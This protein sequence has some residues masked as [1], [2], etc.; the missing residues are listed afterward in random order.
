MNSTVARIAI[1]T[2]EGFILFL[3][4]KGLEIFVTTDLAEG[5]DFPSI[6]PLENV[7]GSLALEAD[8]IIG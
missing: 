5:F 2:C 4:G 6:F 7:G 8:E 1:V 3:G